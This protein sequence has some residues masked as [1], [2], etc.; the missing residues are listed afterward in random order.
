M[1]FKLPKYTQVIEFTIFTIFIFLTIKNTDELGAK[2]LSGVAVL[3]YGKFLYRIW[4]KKEYEISRNILC[5]CDRKTKVEIPISAIKR[6][7]RH[8]VLISKSN[9]FVVGNTFQYFIE[10]QGCDYELDGSYKNENGKSI[11][12]ILTKK[13]N[14]KYYETAG[15][16]KDR[17]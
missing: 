4:I 11:V 2:I 16:Q 15:R 1:K 8:Q 14:K 6:I 10:F 17:N 5:I 9:T 13:Y 7:N 3:V 12:E